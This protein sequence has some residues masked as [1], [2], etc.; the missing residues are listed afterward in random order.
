M[1]ELEKDEL[2][3][4]IETDL[5]E[6]ERGKERKDIAEVNIVRKTIGLATYEGK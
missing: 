4:N 3:S 5:R 2:G 1:K 6:V